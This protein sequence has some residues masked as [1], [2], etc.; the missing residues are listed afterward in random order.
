MGK[1]SHKGVSVVW[2]DMAPNT[3]CRGTRAQG[4]S[5]S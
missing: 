4:Q 3:W 1:P 2:A 5:I